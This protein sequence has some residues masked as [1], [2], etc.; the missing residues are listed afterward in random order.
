MANQR[1]N[2]D[3]EQIARDKIDRMLI[4]AGW[5][6]QSKNEFDRFAGLGV[7]LREYQTPNGTADYVLWVDGDPVGIIEAKREEEGVRLSTVEEQ[8]GEYASQGIKHYEGQAMRFIYESTGVLTRFRDMG[9][10]RP[11]SREV[12]SFHRPDTM[13]RQ[14]Q[15]GNS[16]RANM[17]L[18]PPLHPEGLRHCQFEAI[19]NLE[20]SLKEDKPRALIQMATGAGKTF[21]AITA[22]YRLL[23][24]AKARRVL[25]LVDTRNLGE[26]AEQE[27]ARFMPTDDNRTFTELYSMQRLRSSAIPQGTQVVISTIQRLYSMLTGKEIAEEADEA[28]PAETGT[29]QTVVYNPRVPVEFFD[30]IVIDECHR[31]IYNDWRQVLDYFDAYQVG[32]TATPDNRTYAYFNEN[33]VSDYTY[34]Q[35][36][37]DGVNVDY[38][39][40]LIRTAITTGGAAIEAGEKV[41]KREKLTRKQRWEQLDE[42]ENYSG[43]DLDKKVVNKSQIRHVLRTFRHA[44]PTLFPDRQSQ[45]PKT[46]IFAKSDSH[47]EDIIE[48]VREEFGEGNEFCKKVTYRSQEDP[49]TVLS[50]FRNEYYP[51][52]A[53]TVDMIATGTDIK[54]LECLLFMRDVRSRTY[55]E[56]MK[57]R[58]TRTLSFD[59]LRKVSDKATTA[60]THFVIVDAVG[61]LESHK[62]DSRQLN[63]Q[64]GLS[65]KQVLEQV[66]VGKTGDE[67][68]STAVSRLSRLDKQMTSED[69]KG[70]IEVTGGVSLQELMNR[71]KDATD[72]DTIAQKAE[73]DYRAQGGQGT[74]PPA[75][76]DQARRELEKQVGRIVTG[77]TVDYL[78]KVKQLIEQT[79][80]TVNLDKVLYVGHRQ[81][82]G[83]RSKRLT[84]DFRAYIEQNRDEITALKV[85]YSMPRRRQSLRADLVEELFN[86]LK[87]DRPDLMPTRVY[88]AWA[89]L[90][91]TRN[92]SRPFNDLTALV[93]LVRHIVGLDASLT[94]YG[95]LVRKKFKEWIFKQNAGATQFTPEQVEWLQMLRDHI[96][97]SFHVEMEDLDL[98]PFNDNGGLNRFYSL[99]GEQYTAILAELNEELVA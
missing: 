6:V 78:V 35:A 49:K 10:P 25:F 59:D 1:L 44:L 17:Q 29:K 42:D 93:S 94:P 74:V 79:I 67:L 80:D 90:E 75:M 18:L 85:L 48:L 16:L 96:A 84:Q 62:T 15:V 89:R 14:L 45:V 50:A 36:V 28:T 81:D 95:D 11:R 4:D 83:A 66:M 47:A 38:E 46:L 51:R 40:Y 60:K 12:F 39:E 98:H 7:A 26:Q 70:F 30:A 32:L 55:F 41:Y 88:D 24:F 58:G 63:V 97:T 87:A 5:A 3:P 64:K 57:G 20:Q 77:S 71:L 13:K 2:Q 19:T 37:I 34:E 72:P 52:I 54:P 82:E 53:V 33:V 43:R 68:Y 86:R 56:Q 99:F 22:I 27:F 69:H 61:V 9:D 31:S 73:E 23:K 76:E 21:T 92:T 65:L 91:N 8:S